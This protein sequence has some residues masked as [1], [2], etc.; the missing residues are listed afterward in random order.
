MPKKLEFELGDRLGEELRVE[1]TVGKR[2]FFP[3]VAAMWISLYP[4]VLTLGEQGGGERREDTLGKIGEQA[5]GVCD[6]RGLSW[7]PCG[8]APP[9]LCLFRVLFFLR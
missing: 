3:I 2:S 6:S 5:A 8:Y 1:M 7:G 9:F 4:G